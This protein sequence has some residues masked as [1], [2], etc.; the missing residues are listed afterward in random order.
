MM[1]RGDVVIVDFRSI[2]QASGVRPA[3]V[4]QNDRDNA[5]MTNTLVA[6]LTTKLHRAG[7][8]TQH[9]ID[10]SHRDWAASGLNRPSAV[11]C[12]NLYVVRQANIVRTIGA[13]SPA[14]MKQI[15]GCL[16]AA[17]GIP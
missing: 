1:R 13:L 2:S 4:V 5:R 15:D 8:D 16:K 7:E 14:T 10:P 6:Q 3:L 17:L 11:N 12:S 9:Q